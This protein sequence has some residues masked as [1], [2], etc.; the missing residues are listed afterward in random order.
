MTVIGDLTPEEQGLL[1]SSLDAAAIVVSAASPGRK[2]ET[3][4]EGFAVA[5]YVLESL[6]SHVANPLVAATII[7]LRDR[8]EREER[9]PDYVEL[10]SRPGA[11]QQAEGML[12][13]TSAL[14]EARATPDEAR[15]FREW[16]VAIAEA[17]AG[18]GK[19]D[20]GFLGTG[21]VMVNEKERAAVREVAAMLGVAR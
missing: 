20:Q 9:F 17:A 1:L 15:G 19:E 4:S 21:G 5:E 7:A 10:A 2:E 13:A 3:A 18:A 11:G 8:V 6:G 14:L 12:R 16:L